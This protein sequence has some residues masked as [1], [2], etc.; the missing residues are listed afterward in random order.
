[1]EMYS[2]DSPLRRLAVKRHEGTQFRGVV[3]FQ[4]FIQ[5]FPESGWIGIKR[6]PGLSSPVR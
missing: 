4:R 5:L 6:V 3:F 2:A 1:M